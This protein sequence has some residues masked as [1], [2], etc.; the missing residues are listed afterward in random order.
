M[1]YRPPSAGS[2]LASLESLLGRLDLSSHKR[3]LLV[4]DFNVDVLKKSDQQCLDLSGLTSS[5]GLTQLVNA[6]TCLMLTTASAI[7]HVYSS[8]ASL[9]SSLEVNPPLGSSDHCS[10]NLVLS[11]VR[12]RHRFPRRRIWLF[13]HAG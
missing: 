9:V 5:F 10:I 6:P 3:T 7:D 2:C 13:K 11:L 4:G 1:Y 8:C 12:P